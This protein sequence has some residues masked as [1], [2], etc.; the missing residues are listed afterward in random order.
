[1]D[2]LS[3]IFDAAR[4]FTTGLAGAD[5]VRRYQ[6]RQWVAPSYI[7][8]T[9]QVRHFFVVHILLHVSFY[10]MILPGDFLGVHLINVFNEWI[11]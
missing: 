1:M 9:E 3:S 2:D 8:A 6:L 5:H 11:R 10:E 7:F 4:F